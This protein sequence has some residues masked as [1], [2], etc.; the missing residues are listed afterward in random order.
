MNSEYIFNVLTLIGGL[1][2]FLFGISACGVLCLPVMLGLRGFLLTFAVGCFL[3]VFGGTGIVPVLV[4]FGL[5][6]MFWIP[7]MWI[8]VSSMMECCFSQSVSKGG[9]WKT[10]PGLGHDVA[11][12][13]GISFLLVLLCVFLEYWI[14]PGFLSVTARMVT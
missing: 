9:A 10:A 4:L 8:A 14:L 2:L 3:R 7:A 5:P 12:A 11:A 6:S 1:C 13:L